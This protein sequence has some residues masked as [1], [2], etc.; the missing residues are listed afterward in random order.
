MPDLDDVFVGAGDPADAEIERAVVAEIAIERVQK[1][2]LIGMAMTEKQGG[3]DVRANTT[4]AEH[5]WRRIPLTRAQ[6]VLLR[7]DVRRV[8]G[9]GASAARAFMFLAAALDARREAQWFRMQRLK[10]K[11]GNRSNA[12][13]EVEFHGA[14][15]RLHGRR[16]PRR[17]H[18]HRDGASHATGLR[19]GVGGADAAGVQRRRC[20]TRGIARH[21][22]KLL[23]SQPLMSN[24][25]A[26]LA[27]E[28]EAATLLL[29]RL[30]RAF[31]E[32]DRAFARI[33]VAI[34]KYWLG[35]R[36]PAFVAEALECLGG[37]GYV[38]ES[39]MPRLYR[40]APLN[41][42]WEGS[43]NVIALDVLRAIRKD[44]EALASILEEIRAGDVRVDVPDDSDGR[45]KPV[46]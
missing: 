12:S 1:A 40:E 25:L 11:L 7:A 2:A 31:D 20:I 43:G 42:I 9:A 10:P 46:C 44:P 45:R 36:A 3:S 30:A 24:V 8:S 14:W 16:R 41:S 37:N 5:C 39:I 32:N 29:M 6:V 4:R 22:D 17:R 28:S 18:H 34:G 35:K 21:S 33:G 23:I 13:S 19:D 15:A 38:E 26:D 27:I